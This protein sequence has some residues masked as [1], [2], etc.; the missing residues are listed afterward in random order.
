METDIFQES[1][2]IKVCNY[3]KTEVVLSSQPLS[4]FY[5][6][7]TDIKKLECA[8]H[9]VQCLWTHMEKLVME[10]STYKGSGKSTVFKGG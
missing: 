2:R 8:D 4:M 6:W 7:V 9:A 5:L 3:I 10:K 1:A